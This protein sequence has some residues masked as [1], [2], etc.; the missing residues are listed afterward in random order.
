MITSYMFA[1]LVFFYFFS[2]LSASSSSVLTQMTSKEKSWAGIWGW[3]LCKS[4][5][6]SKTSAPR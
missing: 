5:F 4:S 3:S 2:L 6:G 1:Y